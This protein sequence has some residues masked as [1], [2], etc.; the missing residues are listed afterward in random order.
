M[1][2]QTIDENGIKVKS[3]PAYFNRIVK[4]APAVTGCQNV[5]YVNIN[6]RNC[7]IETKY[8]TV[9]RNKR[10]SKLRNN[11]NSQ[12]CDPIKVS[13]RDN[14]LFVIDGFHRCQAAIDLNLN[15]IPAYLYLNLS[16]KEEI[17]LFL[18]QSVN[19]LPINTK[20]RYFAR[21]ALSD[22][23]VTHLDAIMHKNN[24]EIK[25]TGSKSTRDKITAPQTLIDICDKMDFDDFK[26]WS[27]WV[28]TL[29]HDANWNYLKK[30]TAGSLMIALANTWKRLK[31]DGNLNTG[32]KNL[33]TV[34]SQYGPMHLSFI[35]SLTFP[36]LSYCVHSRLTSLLTVIAEGKYTLQQIQQYNPTFTAKGYDSNLPGSQKKPEDTK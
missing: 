18:D 32:T 30:A 20:E 26:E 33:L 17:D 5:L 27:E 21:R 25:E 3:V 22:P 29:L 11:W 2:I 15:T 28:F 13:Y 23:V 14:K 10:K 6:P 24:F 8:Q 36:E 12:L 1:S 9:T 19:T 16:E 31:N 4:K 7:C 34:M 35:S